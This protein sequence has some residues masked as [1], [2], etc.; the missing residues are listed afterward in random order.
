MLP[1]LKMKAIY[2]EMKQA[3][4]GTVTFDYIDHPLL[5]YESFKQEV[6]REKTLGL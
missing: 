3:P 5:S 1:N 2:L 6:G 4:H